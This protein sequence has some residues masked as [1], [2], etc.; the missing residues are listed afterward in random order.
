MAFRRTGVR[1]L[2]SPVPT[3]EFTFL[4]VGLP[5]ALRVGTPMGFPCSAWLRFDRGGCF[6][7]AGMV[8]S[9][10]LAQ[11]HQ[12]SPAAS[13]RL[14]LYSGPAFHLPKVLITAHTEIHCTFTRPVFPSR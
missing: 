2:D 1:F 13:Q 10:R 9:A 14:I 11:P 8:V 4:A 5:A 6:L 3:G 7:Y 12:P